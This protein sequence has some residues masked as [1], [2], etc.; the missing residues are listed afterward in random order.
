MKGIIMK[1]LVAEIN[2]ELHI[3]D[4]NEVRGMM[5]V[6]GNT[7]SM[8]RRDEMGLTEEEDIA[9]AKMYAAIDNKLEKLK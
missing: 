6:I 2:I 5:K 4:M 1:I 7:S 8:F 3:T 9:V